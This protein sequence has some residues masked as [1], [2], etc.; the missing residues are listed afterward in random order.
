MR[1]VD[2]KGRKMSG[3][4]PAAQFDANAWGPGTSHQLRIWQNGQYTNFGLPRAAKKGV[5]QAAGS[6]GH[7]VLAVLGEIR[8]ELRALRATMSFGGQVVAG[9]QGGSEAVGFPEDD[10]PF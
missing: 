9:D 10:C 3:F 6:N 5:A 8:D 1:I 4:V 2:T 7:A